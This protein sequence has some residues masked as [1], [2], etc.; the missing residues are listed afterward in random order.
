VAAASWLK[1]VYLSRASQ[2]KSERALYRLV[3]RHKVCRIV[4]VGIGSLARTTR[5]VEV[6]Q[7]YARGE[8]VAYTG[9]D[10]FDT[11]PKQQPPLTL[12]G[13]H[14]HLQKTAATVRLVPGPPARS[15]AT[16]A[17]AHRGTG[18]LLISA[19]V[20]DHELEA[21]WFYV[22][23]MLTPRSLVLREEVDPEGE[24]KF[25]QLSLDQIAQ[26]VVRTGSRRAA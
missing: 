21:A 26:W 15:L 23:R 3:K 12:K 25:T 11:R 9:L 5:L 4:E 22:P 10:L 13:S 17:N 24:S 1:Y 19:A 18:M 8:E 20:A 6:A 7:R 16:V 2:P 14:C